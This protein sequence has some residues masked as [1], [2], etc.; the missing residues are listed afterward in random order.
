MEMINKLTEHYH[1]LMEWSCKTNEGRA[2]RRAIKSSLLLIVAATISYAQN[3]P[4]YL[5]LAPI[6]MGLEKYLRDKYSTNGCPPVSP[7]Q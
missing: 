6:L 5:A 7:S 4:K 3:D 2:V 1:K